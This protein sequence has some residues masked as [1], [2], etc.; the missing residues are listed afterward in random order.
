[1]YAHGKTPPYS[2]SIMKILVVTAT[3]L[4]SVNGVAIS[5]KRMVDALR[6][7]G[8]EIWILGPEFKNSTEKSYFSFQTAHNIPGLPQDYPLVLPWIS[9]KTRVEIERKKW[10]IIHVH[11]PAYV[12]VM[13]LKIGERCGAPV[14]F[15]Y[16]SQYDQVV[17]SN[18]PFFPDWVYELIFYVGAAKVIGKMAAIIATTSWLR[19]ELVTKFPEI[20]I[21]TVST[22]GLPASFESSISKHELRK[23]LSIPKTDTVF[24]VVSRLSVE[25]NVGFVLRAF[26]KWNTSHKRSRLIIIGDGNDR[27]RL[28]ELSK[29]LGIFQCVQFIGKI[30]NDL[31]M[32]WLNA[33]DL[34]LYSSVTD[35]VSVNIVEAM[36]SGLPVVALDD[37]TTRELVLPG[38]NGYLSKANLTE[39]TDMMKK[40]LKEREALSEGAKKHIQMNYS[41]QVTSSNL[42]KT[43][44]KIITNY[45][46]NNH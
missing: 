33:A 3:Y 27:I 19:K 29:K 36:S 8:H 18:I 38:V 22:A 1:M 20:P 25:K 46:T 30:S 40:A 37:K 12:S 2:H 35:T 23:Q 44:E 15:T 10:D 4:P 13:A 17:K 34:F 39:Y 6:N 7:A 24:I 14:V 42:I 5:T 28:E 11:H 31:L 9:E 32:P 26:K 21:Y 45:H 41:L 43:Y 16:H